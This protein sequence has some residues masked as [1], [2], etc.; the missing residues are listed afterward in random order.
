MNTAAIRSCPEERRSVASSTYMLSSDVGM[1]TG[2][3]IM[4]FVIG[5]GGYRTMFLCSTGFFGIALAIAIYYFKVR[6]K[7]VK[8]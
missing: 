6:M 2:G 1:G 8:L 3:F 4:S 5:L 7:G